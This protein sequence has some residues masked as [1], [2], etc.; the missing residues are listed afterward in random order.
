M[1]VI[2]SWQFQHLAIKDILITNSGNIKNFVMVRFE[3]CGCLEFSIALVWFMHLWLFLPPSCFRVWLSIVTVCLPSCFPCPYVLVLVLV[4]VTPS[5]ILIV[6]HLCVVFS[7]SSLYLASWILFC[8]QLFP[9]SPVTSCVYLTPQCPSLFCPPLQFCSPWR[10]VDVV[11][12][13]S[14]LFCKFFSNKAV[15]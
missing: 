7:F 10:F 4:F 6:S 1:N 13:T 9:L 15:F 11:S 2:Q 3:F 8:S 12:V 5:F 14:S